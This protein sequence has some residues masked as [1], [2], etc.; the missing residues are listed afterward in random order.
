MHTDNDNDNQN[1]KSN[2]LSINQVIKIENNKIPKVSNFFRG[3]IVRN[4]KQP[5]KLSY[6]VKEIFQTSRIKESEIEPKL[7]LEKFPAAFQLKNS[8]HSNDSKA[9]NHTKYSSNEQK[10]SNNETSPDEVKEINTYRQKKRNESLNNYM[11]EKEI[12]SLQKFN[13][14]FISLKACSGSNSDNCKIYHNKTDLSEYEDLIPKNAAKNKMIESKKQYNFI[15]STFN[16]S[17]RDKFKILNKNIKQS[18]FSMNKKNNYVC[19]ELLNNSD[20]NKNNFRKSSDFGVYPAKIK[21]K[22]NNSSLMKKDERSCSYINMVNYQNF[23]QIE[24]FYSPNITNENIYSNIN[25]NFSYVDSNRRENEHLRLSAKPLLHPIIPQRKNSHETENNKKMKLSKKI[26]IKV[27]NLSENQKF[28]IIKKNIFKEI[29]KKKVKITDVNINEG[30]TFKSNNGF[31]Y[32]FNLRYANIYFLKEVQY[33]LTKDISTSINTWNKYFKSN[34]DYLNIIC[35]KLNTPENHYTLVVEYP[36]GGESLYDI[37]NSIG[38]I[39]KKLVF[40]TI[41]KIYNNIL[42]LKNEEKEPLKE[43]QNIPFCLCNLFLTINEELKIMPPIIRKIPINSSK[44]SDINYS[45]STIDEEKSSSTCQCRINFDILKKYF[46]ITKNNISFFCLGLSLLQLITQNLIFKFK[47][48]NIL[49]NNSKGKNYLKCCLLHSL[50]FIEEN[51][52]NKKN[53]LLLSNFLYE[54]DDKFINFIHQCTLFEEIKKY[55]NIEF[56]N[57]HPIIEKKLD[58]SMRELFKIISLNNN[59]YISLDNFLNNFKLLFN[60]MKIEKNYFNVLIHENK[61]IDIIKRCFNI[62]KRELKIKIYKIIDNNKN[63]DEDFNQNFANSGNC[64]FNA[65]SMKKMENNN[66]NK[67]KTI[68][69][70]HNN[71][72]YNKYNKNLVIFS[73]Y[74]ISENNTNNDN[75]NY[76]IY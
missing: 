59:N 21:Q 37:V 16:T 20:M 10:N 43:Y 9:T 33:Y 36:K 41:S 72:K 25:S 50:L 44:N 29:N 54:Y 76:D 34:E 71:M 61:V 66:N 42:K 73:N 35:L 56:I 28:S 11:I 68:N 31:K 65:S 17:S 45:R 58:L 48:Y 51:K 14:D 15:N 46:K 22:E 39:E 40:L 30:I 62:D 7:L 32:Y 13:N 49:V 23:P 8:Q 67:I 64:F 26:N 27:K 18:T 1:L 5:K 4:N 12:K 52:C 2:I 60:N 38:L 3:E 74:N 53:D 70:E 55:P 24:S 6:D 75:N 57:C 19:N 47:S 69:N 63:E